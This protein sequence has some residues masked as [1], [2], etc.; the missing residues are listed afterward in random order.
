MAVVPPQSSGSGEFDFGDH[1]NNYPYNIAPNQNDSSAITLVCSID[2]AELLCPN[3][4]I[5]PIITCA[6]EN[7]IIAEVEKD[8]HFQQLIF[9]RT[10]Y[11]Y[12]EK[13]L[14]T[15]KLKEIPIHAIQR[16]RHRFT[17]IMQD[18]E[19]K[20]AQKLKLF[21]KLFI[22]NLV[23]ATGFVIERFQVEALTDENQAE[24]EVQISFL[25]ENESFM[26]DA[27]CDPPI[28]KEFNLDCGGDGI[29]AIPPDNCQGT[30]LATSQVD[31][32]DGTTN[33][34]ATTSGFGAKEEIFWFHNGEMVG[35]G[36][37]ITV[38][39][40]G[41]YCAR[42][43]GDGCSSEECITIT[44][45]C[46]AEITV[47]SS[48]CNTIVSVSN[49]GLHSGD[50]LQDGVAVDGYFGAADNSYVFDL[51]SGDYIVTFDQGGD[52]QLISVPFTVAECLEEC[53]DVYDTFTFSC[54]YDSNTDSYTPLSNDQ[55]NALIV[56][57][58]FV[59]IN[60]GQDYA[61]YI[62]GGVA[63]GN[64]ALFRWDVQ[65][66]GC[67]P[68]S[69]YTACGKQCCPDIELP[70]EPISVTIDN[71]VQVEG[72]FCCGEE[73]NGGGTDGNGNPCPDPIQI[74]GSSNVV[75]ERNDAFGVFGTYFAPSNADEIHFQ[76]NGTTYVL[77]GG[78]TTI[79][80]EDCVWGAAFPDSGDCS[81]INKS[82]IWTDDPTA[83]DVTF[84]LCFNVDI[85]GIYSFGFGADNAGTVKVDGVQIFNLENNGGTATEEQY[86]F[87]RWFIVEKNLSAGQHIIEVNAVNADPASPN[88]VGFEIYNATAA[89][90]QALTTEAEIDAMVHAHSRQINNVNLVF[91][92]AGGLECPAGTTAGYNGC[93]P[94]CICDEDY[95]PTDLTLNV[96]QEGYLL[97]AR[98][99][100]TDVES[101]EW[102]G[103][104]GDGMG[105]VSVGSGAN[106]SANQSGVYYVVV[107]CDTETLQSAQYVVGGGAWL[108]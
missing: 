6:K 87:K 61:A 98:S 45:T 12:E 28:T 77:G 63:S 8:L 65:L 7:D 11:E 90:L 76:T 26:I 33:L 9:S 100:C 97:M 18:E 85:G 96:V 93:N 66:D 92:V 44:D 67:E 42:V 24:Y 54:S 72:D 59:S 27:C 94:V 60:G 39:D 31:N 73:T 91:N 55:G 89:Q 106:Y 74:A 83:T 68:M 3:F 103:D 58:M 13:V 48:G 53:T 107:T 10:D 32:G 38:S 4:T 84:A 30:T 52:C 78:G 17:T 47:Q 29:F 79:N 88:T 25:V 16:Y 80:L 64:V 1:F 50:I 81:R 57:N 51:P 49:V 23:E 41:V 36:S 102:F 69:L 40:A 46:D 21:K 62:G 37:L 22:S 5:S 56:D 70:T 71:V 19:F 43:V 20:R 86:T 2:I 104:L 108:L 82:G 35:A 101:F 14:K 105:F 95:V 15:S 99:N 34:I 75:P